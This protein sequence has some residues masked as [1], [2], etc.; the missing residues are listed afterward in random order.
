MNCECFFTTSV[1]RLSSK[2]SVWSYFRWRI[3]LVLRPIG[4]PW[5]AQT[6]K[7]LP[8]E[9]SQAYCSS[10]LCFVITTTFSATR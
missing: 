6:V 3:T 8:A 2:Y 7:E 5:S 10:L 1:T 9:D 4:S